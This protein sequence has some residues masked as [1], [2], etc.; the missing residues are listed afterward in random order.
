VD[1]TGLDHQVD[2]IV[3]HQA[4]EALGDAAQFELQRPTALLVVRAKK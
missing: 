4:A 3:G 1:L 2:G